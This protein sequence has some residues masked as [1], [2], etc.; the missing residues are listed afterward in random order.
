VS[1]TPIERFTPQGIAVNGV[2]YPLDTVVCATGFA[3]MTGSFDRIRITGRKGLTLAEKWQAGPRTYLGL[4]TVGFPNLF[5]IT[6]PGSPSVLASMIQAIEQHV[7][8]ISDCMA[9]LRDI[10]AATI[11]A[12]CTYEDDWVEHVNEVSQVSLRSTCS[13][14]YV[15]ANIPGRPRVFM[16]YIGG[17]PIYVQ[18]CN[19]V[20][21]NGFEGFVIDARA[22]NDAPRV[23]LTERWRVPLDIEVISPA[24]IAARRVPVV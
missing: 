24:A 2:E 9:H 23:R 1:K 15:G 4:A 8:W 22:R 18:K 5:T 6:G 11:E 7:D 19:E 13:S 20:M 17:F 12:T 14:W 16:P 3:A 21:T 10:G